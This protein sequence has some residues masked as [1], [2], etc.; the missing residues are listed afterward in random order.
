[1]TQ[2]VIGVYRVKVLLSITYLSYLLFYNINNIFDCDI[3]FI[4]LFRIIQRIPWILSLFN[5][6][7]TMHYQA[8][9]IPFS[10]ITHMTLLARRSDDHYLYCQKSS[11]LETAIY[12]ETY[13]ALG[14]Y[15]LFLIIAFI[16]QINYTIPKKINIELESIPFSLIIKWNQVDRTC[17][18][19]LD[20]LNETD[21][22]AKI[23]CEHY[24]HLDCMKEWV[25]KAQI[26]PRCKTQIN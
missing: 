12:F 8:L 26:C 23:K 1:M 7:E 9:C 10:L 5:D 20:N 22:L 25:K 13:L 21:L 24:D 18:I 17:C 14:L 2:F 4:G 19:C 16:M 3:W 6:K 15:A 11:D